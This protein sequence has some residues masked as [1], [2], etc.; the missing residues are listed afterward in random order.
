MSRDTYDVK[1]EYTGDGSL[2]VYT[3]DFKIEAKAQ[4]LVIELDDSGEET[5]RVDGNDTTY[6]SG[7]VFD[8]VN[9]GGTVTLAANLANNYE[10]ILLLAND[11]PTQPYQFG[12]KNSFSLKRFEAALDFAVGAIQRLAYRGKQALRIHDADDEETF[13][14]QFP[15]GVAE[16]DNNGRY[17]K[18]NDDGDGFEYGITEE[19]IIEAAFPSNPSAEHIVRYDGADWVNSYYGGGG[20]QITA[21]QSVGAGGTIALGLLAQQ[22][23]KVQGSSGAQTASTTPFD[24]APADG[25]VITLKGEHATNTLMIPYADI[26]EGCMLKGDCFLGLYDTLTLVYDLTAKR[27]IEISRN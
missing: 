3:F 11:D 20:M 6:L 23:L 12:N 16:T 15:P 24:S 21:V 2:A 18:I 1:E 14:A 25:T 17:L 27:Y 4:L 5:E 13:D 8:A 10:L 7:V 26:D 9:G 19:E 22:L